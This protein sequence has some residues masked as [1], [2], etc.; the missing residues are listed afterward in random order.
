[1]IFVGDFDILTLKYEEMRK[2]MPIATI[3]PTSK[4]LNSKPA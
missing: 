1:M 2:I 4:F 3:L